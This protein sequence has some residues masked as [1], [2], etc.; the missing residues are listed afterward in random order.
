M[1]K[2]IKGLFNKP[3]QTSKNTEEA[4]PQPQHIQ[5]IQQIQKTTNDPLEKVKN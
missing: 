5:P 2:Y 4:S 3:G 1:S